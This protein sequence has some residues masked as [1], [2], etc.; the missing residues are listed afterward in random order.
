MN[1]EEEADDSHDK[2]SSIYLFWTL[3]LYI[4]KN[5]FD[6]PPTPD[7][8][9]LYSGDGESSTFTEVRV[10][11]IDVVLTHLLKN[12]IDA[13][14]N[15]TEQEVDFDLEVTNICWYRGLILTKSKSCIYWEPKVSYF[16]SGL[17]KD[18]ISSITDC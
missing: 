17:I 2:V 4:F 12:K 18:S 1:A 11:C 8:V 14:D 5:G 6:T 15:P 7:T 9:I 13:P 3:K 10:I 16:L